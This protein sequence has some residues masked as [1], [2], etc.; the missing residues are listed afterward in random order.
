MKNNRTITFLLATMLAWVGIW[1][2]TQSQ[3]AQAASFGA[4][5]KSIQRGDTTI[6]AAA[7]TWETDTD[8]LPSAVV[9]NRSILLITAASGHLVFSQPT[10]YLSDTTTITYEY[11]VSGQNGTLMEVRWV[12]IEY[13]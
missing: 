1:L 4:G 13:Y 3:Q 11:D 2:T 7:G 9:I 8:T 12:V 10:A 5:I 6:T